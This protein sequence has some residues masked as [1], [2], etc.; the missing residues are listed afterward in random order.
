MEK[1]VLISEHVR[2]L[3]TTISPLLNTKITFFV[4]F[5]KW[6]DLKNPITLNEK[7]QRL[8]L[9]EYNNNKLVRECADKYLV[10]NYV[11]AC[12]LDDILNELIE[13][14]ES[15][16][17][18]KWDN[19]PNQFAIKLNVGCG[20]NH[21]VTDFSKEQTNKLEEEISKW[22]KESRTQWKSYSE[23]QYKE[24]KPYILIER[25]IGNVTSGELPNDYKV[26]CFNGKPRYTMVCTGRGDEKQLKYY[27]FDEKWKLARINKDSME[28]PQDFAMD[29][30]KCFQQMID[31]AHRLSKPFPFVRVD[32]YINQNKL[33]F[34]EMTFTPSG[35]MDTDRLPK[36]DILMGNMLQLPTK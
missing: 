34:G 25:Y 12:G 32:F 11:S 28:A 30:P 2:K 27:F 26:Y 6:L 21:I 18:I 17:D 5:H 35:G 23:L 36:T 20:F 3:L 15:P 1:R 24:I 16:C 33:L 13:V 29:Q 31:A 14:Y 22:I 8:K 10:R 7:I 19:L 9:Y 4:K